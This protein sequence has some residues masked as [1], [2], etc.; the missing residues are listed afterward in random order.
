MQETRP[1]SRE[2]Q[3]RLCTQF[4]TEAFALI[5][6]KVLALFGLVLG[7][8]C[9]TDLACA[10]PVDWPTLSFTR[11][12]TNSFGA[13]TCITHA[14]DGSQRLFIVEQDGRVWIVQSNSLRVQPFLEVTNRVLRGIEQGLLG[15]AFSP[16]FATNSH[17]YVDYTRKPDGA[18]VISRFSLTP[19]NSDIADPN[20]EQNLKVIPQ[21]FPNHNGGQLAFGPDGYLYIGMGDGGYGPNGIGDPNNNAQN[22]A[23]LLGK[24][25]RIDTES[26]VAP[27]AVPASNPF[28]GNT[29]YAP[30]IWALGLRNPWRFSFD[31]L[32]GDLYIG[33]VGHFHYEEID[34]QPA[35][36]AGGQ[37]YGWRILEGPFPYNM[38]TG[39]D[40][41][42]LTG[43]VTWYDHR[44]TLSDDGGSVTG[45]YVYR[46]PDHLRMNGL[47]IFGDFASSQMWALKAQGT[48]WQRLE[49]PNP[50]A[51]RA[52]LSTFGEDEQGNLYMADYYQGAVYQIQDTHQVWTPAFV[53]ANG[54]INSNAVVIT[55]LTPGALIHYTSNGQDP[56]ESD[57]SV[58][59]GGQIPVSNNTTN[60]IR[61]FRADLNPSAIV[62]AA[63]SLKVATPVFAPAA[64]PVTNGTL[65]TLHTISPAAVIYYNA[66]GTVPT[67]N[68]LVYSEPIAITNSVT[69]QAVGIA[70]GLSNSAVAVAAYSIA[71]VAAPVFSPPSGPI[72]NGTRISIS[73]PTPGAVIFYTIDESTPTTESLAYSGP[74]AIDGDVTL[75][76]FCL[77]PGY[78]DSDVVSVFYARVMAAIPTFTPAQGPLTNYTLIS[79]QSAT[80]GGIIR[81]TLDGSVPDSSSPIYSAPLVFSNSMTLS[82][83]SFR[84]DLDSSDV[85]SVY[86]GLVDYERVVVTTFVGQTAVGFSNA[87][88]TLAQFSAPQGVCVDPAGNLYVADTGNNVIRKVSRSG[89]V[90]TFA[91][92][93][94]GG[95]QLGPA[96]EAQFS[97]PTGVCV[98]SAGNVFVADGNNCNR[99][100]KIDSNGIVSVLAL[101]RGSNCMFYGP[102]LWQITADPVGNV[103]VGSWATVEKILPDG[104]VIKLAGPGSCCGQGWGGAV[105]PAIDAMNNIYAATSSTFVPSANHIWRISPSGVVDLF[106]GITGEFTDGPRLRSAFQGPQDSAVDSAGNIFV[107]DISRIRKIRPDGWV[108]TLA[109]SGAAGIRDGRGSDAQFNHAKGMC[110]DTNGNIYVADSGNNC[111]R[112]I[113]P[114]TAG[115]GIADDWQRAHFGYV[116]IDP[117]ADPDHDGMSNFAEFWAGTD[118]LDPNSSLAIDTASLRNGNQIQISWHSVLGKNYTINY[119]NDLIT[120]NPLGNPIPGNGAVISITDPSPIG[121]LSQR[122]YRVFLSN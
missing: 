31:R 80:A 73:S 60:K 48:N 91:G 27:Y 7:L 2:D 51:G 53:P 120:W 96:T 26:G 106:A 29:N 111:I 54:T 59:S 74:I 82:A 119:S 99:V 23:S 94:I 56:T 71:Q 89:Q 83:R 63:F 122:F 105:G 14:G 55:C 68:S 38:P 86:Y 44:S 112:K 21:P 62:A 58:A 19:T 84:G 35:G 52:G 107:S 87:V 90:T 10:E 79:M 76:A 103:Y 33:D 113:S 101:V 16:G 28:V 108:S 116:G 45:G 118:P 36:S 30:E 117:N 50:R 43:P 13:P 12:I 40:L 92:T 77:A 3:Y 32:T 42:V 65:V 1:S 39:I 104:T 49:M 61:A 47:Y 18:T 15:L 70:T 25:L 34:F 121:Q 72:T 102:G 20:S 115:I 66:D 78:I 81:Y 109:G 11:S 4:P 69:L 5:S 93:G 67:T 8:I 9:S 98:D 17:F 24:L 64:G 85:M 22:P 41:S 37:N 6:R 110:V 57:P 75:S 88:A 95:S 114:D 46:G 97:A 100:C